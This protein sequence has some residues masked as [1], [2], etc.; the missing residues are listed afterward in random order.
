MKEPRTGKNEEV[1]KKARPDYSAKVASAAR[2]AGRASARRCE[3]APAK[4][5]NTLLGIPKGARSVFST[6]QKISSIHDHEEQQDW[7]FKIYEFSIVKD[8][9]AN[10][11]GSVDSLTDF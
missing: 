7:S 11:P 9:I 3:A 1:F 5:R 4:T 10:D 2:K 6:P 8:K